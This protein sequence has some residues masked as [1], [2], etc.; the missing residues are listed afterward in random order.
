MATNDLMQGEIW[1]VDLGYMQGIKRVVVTK[2]ADAVEGT[3]AFG[4]VLENGR[5][6]LD[7]TVKVLCRDEEVQHGD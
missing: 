4:S 2:E 6:R 7:D 5:V 3:S 1:V